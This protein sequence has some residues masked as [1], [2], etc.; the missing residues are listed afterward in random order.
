MLAPRGVPGRA[1]GLVWLVPLFVVVPMLP[2][3]GAF[4][5]TVL[6][7]GQGLAVLVQT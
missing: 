4:R 2:A 5:L 6:D 1:L 3:P 7:V